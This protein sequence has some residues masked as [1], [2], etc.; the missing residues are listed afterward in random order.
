MDTLLQDLRFG[1]RLLLRQ[2]A[3]TLLVVLTLALGIGANTSIF[4]VVN[5]VLLSPLPYP[6]PERLVAVWGHHPDIGRESASLPDFLDWRE[7]ARSFEQ[8]AAWFPTLYNVTGEGEPERVV[9][10]R[11]TANFFQTLGISPARGRAFDRGE[12]REGKTT[13]VVLS[14]GFWKRRMG[15]DPAALGRTLTLNGV[16]HTVIG[17][18]PESFR[19]NPDAEMW[20]PLPMDTQSN[21]RSDFLRVIGRLAPSATVE[22]A[23]EELRA[24]MRRLA[25]QY[26]DTNARWTVEAVSLHEDLVGESRPALLI[27]MGAVGL[28]LLIACANVANLMLARSARRQ[29][30]LAVRAAL[31][32][33]RLRLVRQMLTESIL[34]A[35][36]GGGLG[37]LLAVWGIDGLRAAGLDLVPGQTEIGIDEQ[38]LA[39]T[40]GLSLVTGVLFGLAPALRLPGS[41]LDDTLRAGARGL[42]GGMGLRQ[43]RGLLVLGEVALAL[44]LLVGAALLLRSFDR[45]QRVDTGFEPEGVLTLRLLLPAS[46]YPGDPQLAAFYEQLTERVA[47]LPGVE[48]AGIINAVPLASGTPYNTFTIQGRAPD[49]NAVEDAET[50]SVSPGYFRSLGIP[51]RSGRLL[52]SQDGASAQPVALINE[53]MARRFWAGRDP[54]GARV[55]LDATNWFTVVGIVGDVRNAALQKEPHAQL[56]FPASQLPRRAMFLAVRTTGEPMGLVGSLRREVSTLDPDLPLADI[57]TME[58]RLGRAAAKPRVNVLLLGG[59]AAVAL[60]LA[61]I[62]IYGVISQM[63]VQRTREIG[64]RMALGARQRDVLRLMILQGMTPALVGIALGLAVAWASSR[65]MAKLLY[66]VS[67]TDPV[68]FFTVPIFLAAVAFLAAWLP[69]R[70]ARRVDPTEALRQE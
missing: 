56:Y 37:L 57:A 17:I 21:R 16:P 60:L 25:E 4:S 29:R 10:V 43:L 18:A 59:F 15:E 35:L 51:L 53:T 1:L 36:M 32:A 55:S 64:I 65:L 9:G 67:A 22:Q 19:F 47:A 8:L 68:S 39:F 2:P 11:T 62:G 63:V 49:P 58:Q 41:N 48:A 28:V 70:R 14:H 20:V 42:T 26:P 27:F 46:K 40:V 30:E 44:V 23:Q 24:V 38:V 6:A 34:L 45:L 5:G 54:L 12:D 66:G 7:G 69:A 3:F 13:V 31:G 52:E 61:G 33:S 50:F